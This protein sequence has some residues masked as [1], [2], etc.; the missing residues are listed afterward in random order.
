MS[1]AMFTLPSL[2][3]VR[4]LS[5]CAILLAALPLSRPAAAAT[6]STILMQLLNA[7]RSA[8]A[9]CSGQAA[10]AVPPLMPH[11]AL[12]QV[13]VAPGVFLDQALEQAGYLP[14]QV[15]AIEVTGPEDAPA[16]MAELSERYCRLLL[17][18]RF[19]HLGVQRQGNR[20]L[21]LLARE[22]PP[23][24]RAGQ[25]EW[26]SAGR[27]VLAATNAA[28]A[29]AR[30]CGDRHY[31]AAP[32]LRW[33]EKLGQ[34]ARAHSDDMAGRRYFNHRA[35]DGS[36]AGERA[37]RAG[38]GWRKIGENIASGQESPQEAVQGWIASPGHCANL[39][40]PDFTDM[41]ASY[42]LHSDRRHGIIYW[43]QVFGTP[44]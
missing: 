37:L 8:P 24:W 36:G 26:S 4:P 44:R 34:A 23:R 28:R 1:I 15:Q 11:A 17:D 32:P 42:A 3:H 2:S 40:N 13:Q 19:Q 21:V 31:P 38:Y 29:Q 18:A 30:R 9:S 33:N 5:G 27:E 25:P 20:W 6:D 22:A 7:Y 43:T 10:R 39:M 41:G 35:R 14:E 16:A 12:V